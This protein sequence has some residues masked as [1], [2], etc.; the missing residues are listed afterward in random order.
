MAHT[1]RDKQKLLNRIRRI[2]GQVEAIE[3]ALV[4]ESDCARILQTVTSCRGALNGFMAQI[5]EGHVRDHVLDPRRGVTAAQTE[6]VED[7][8]GVVR[9]YL[10]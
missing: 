4:E 2:K 9:A 3:K 10:R 6:A 8:M 5:V 7:L 1:A